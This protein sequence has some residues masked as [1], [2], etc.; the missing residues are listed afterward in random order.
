MEECQNRLVEA[1]GCMLVFH[2]DYASIWGA[3]DRIALSDVA[4]EVQGLT[5]FAVSFKVETWLSSVISGFYRVS[6]VF[7]TLGCHSQWGCRSVTSSSP[8]NLSRHSVR[9]IV[10]F[11]TCRIYYASTPSVVRLMNFTSQRIV[12]SLR[13][14]I[15]N[16][17]FA[18]IDLQLFLHDF[19]LILDRR[20][21]LVFQVTDF[22]D[23]LLWCF[24]F[25]LELLNFS[26]FLFALVI[27]TL[28]AFSI[29]VVVFL[30]Q[31][32]FPLSGS[33][34]VVFDLYHLAKGLLQFLQ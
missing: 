8:L 25:L 4:P 12:F 15:A 2:W 5:L 34:D 20:S 11:N 10:L 16:F 19:D 33:N 6:C 3:R 26:V 13:S 18:R 27:E 32:D 1:I 30:Q 17:W 7:R 31:P 21:L 9:L 22:F 29:K 28:I 23:S 24:N 14:K